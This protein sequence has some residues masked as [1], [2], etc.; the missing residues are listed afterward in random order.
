[1]RKPT[2]SQQEYWDNVLHDH[3]LG[4]DRGTKVGSKKLEYRGD[5]NDLDV[6]QSQEIA[7]VGSQK[8]KGHGPE[9]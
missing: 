2:K 1:M 5:T 7:K 9:W 3:R 6:V 4:M 8:P